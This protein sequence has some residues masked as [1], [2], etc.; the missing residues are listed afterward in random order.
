[1]NIKKIFAVIP[2]LLLFVSC[3]SK[4]TA[5]FP[6]E[7][8]GKDVVL[9]GNSKRA[10]SGQI[11]LTKK[12]SFVYTFETPQSVLA[13][14][15]L[16]IDYT[17]QGEGNVVLTIEGSA[18]QQ[19]QMPL[20]AS[21]M[22]DALPNLIR[23]AVPLTDSEITKIS[24]DVSG[25][26]KRGKK[27]DSALEIK[28]FRIRNRW[29]GF[30]WEDGVFSATPF[31]EKTYSTYSTQES[32]IVDPPIDYRINGA[33]E[34]WVSA[35]PKEAS[36]ND[37][38]TVEPGTIFYEWTCPHDLKNAL[39]LPPGALTYNPYPLRVTISPQMGKIRLEASQ[40]RPFPVTPIPAD[41]GIILSYKEGYWRD[42]RYEVFQWEGF[43][44]ILIF[45]TASYAVQDKFFKRL[46]FFVEKKDYR[47]KLLTDAALVGQHGWN[48]YDYR[49]EDLAAFFEIAETAS[50]LL[51]PEEEELK[52]ILLNNG[53]LKRKSNQ[54]ID[55]GIGAVISISRG[56]SDYLR[57]QFMAHEG[58]HG[59]FF[60]DKEF[61]DFS[62][63]RYD[64]L[65][66]VARNFILSFFD[67]QRYDISDNYLAVNEFQAHILQQSVSQAGWYFGGNLAA[68]LEASPWRRAILPKKDEASAT[69]PEIAAA[70][71]T[72]ATAF[73]AYVNK[74]WGLDAGRTWRVTVR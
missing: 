15:S 62:K 56:S 69:W 44:S 23:Y 72:E 8:G 70:F 37:R 53:I 4:K 74:R 3:S 20:D 10:A 55:A 7:N 40:V 33:I 25:G 18:V 68:R 24:L 16:E 67:Y 26:G 65:S 22:T 57:R 58:F 27:D 34:L 19:W 35:F 28:A 49:A 64:H 30:E 1:M 31:V 5:S 54:K 45:D 17:V 12:A 71:Q 48:A 47:G 14:S 6:F 66:L 50:F 73:S 43:P 29:F 9:F 11:T 52:T 21:L 42:S 63:D 36:G 46:A 41:P 51:L 13:D 59:V 61:R 38:I 32:W 39:F 2:A 60:I